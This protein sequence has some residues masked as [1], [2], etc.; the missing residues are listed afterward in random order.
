MS[1][2][3]KVTSDHLLA[4]QAIQISTAAI[5]NDKWVYDGIEQRRFGQL[6]ISETHAKELSENLKFIEECLREGFTG[7][8]LEVAEELN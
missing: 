1:A 6:N 7:L 3:K 4:S 8:A 2:L 5:S